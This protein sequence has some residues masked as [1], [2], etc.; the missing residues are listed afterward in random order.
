M[1][2]F[3]R[4]TGVPLK[5]SVKNIEDVL[6]AHNRR[7][8]EAAKRRSAEEKAKAERAINRQIAAAKPKSKP[9]PAP[10]RDDRFDGIHEVMHGNVRPGRVHARHNTATRAVFVR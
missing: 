7:Q 1:I 4:R 6:R 2:L 9:K 3:P 5:F 10:K 8:A